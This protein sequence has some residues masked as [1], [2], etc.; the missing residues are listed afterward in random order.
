MFSIHLAEYHQF[1]SCNF[2]PTII[3]IKPISI[4]VEGIPLFVCE[5]FVNDITVKMTKKV[6]IQVK[7]ERFR[8]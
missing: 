5:W 8:L 3:N 1:R 7:L 6:F 4:S 2:I